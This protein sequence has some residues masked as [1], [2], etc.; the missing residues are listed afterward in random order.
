MLI[1]LTLEDNVILSLVEDDIRTKSLLLYLYCTCTLS[2]RSKYTNLIWG[3]LM[4]FNSGRVTDIT[5]FLSS[6]ESHHLL[7]L[8]SIKNENLLTLYPI[9]CV[10]Y[11][12]T[13]T[14][15]NWV[16]PVTVLYWE[17]GSVKNYKCCFLLRMW[18]TQGQ[19]RILI[20]GESHS[21]SPLNTWVWDILSIGFGE[22]RR[23][24]RCFQF[25]G[26]HQWHSS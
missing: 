6:K 4:L 8:Y 7:V 3:V 14:T 26:N 21:S 19:V 13:N 24:G 20:E 22:D 15:H 9:E 25:T 12:N 11:S 23:S 5:I 10:N 17:R 2:V 1:L 16:Y 18:I